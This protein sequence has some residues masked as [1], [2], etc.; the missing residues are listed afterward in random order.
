MNFKKFNRIP[1]GPYLED[2]LA[3]V[4]SKSK[5]VSGPAIYFWRRSYVPSPEVFETAD[6]AL[7]WIEMALQTFPLEI[8]SGMLHSLVKINGI[9]L[10]GSTITPKKREDLKAALFD[11]TIRSS[12][13]T[14]LSK[15]EELSVPIYIGQTNNLRKR[16]A[17]HINDKTD[18]SKY[19]REVLKEEWS[20]MALWV[21]EFEPDS[22]SEFLELFEWISQSILAPVAVRRPG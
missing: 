10:C 19:L 12:A 1:I 22:T 2:I 9:R 17:D 5:F 20:S 3:G 15:L 8:S 13:L 18:F 16:V 21:Y 6:A 14:F 11:H 7:A 4:P